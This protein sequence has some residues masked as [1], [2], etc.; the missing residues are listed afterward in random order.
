MP[1]EAY[2]K[3]IGKYKHLSAEQLAHIQRT[4]ND[5]VTSLQ[6]MAHSAR[7]VEHA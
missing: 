1:V 4:V 7:K 6:Q 3:L 2:L 5:K